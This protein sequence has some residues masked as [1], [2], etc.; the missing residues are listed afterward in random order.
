MSF[1]IIIRGPLGIGKSTI[2]KEL[3]RRL[4][5]EYISIDTILEELDLDHIDEGLGCIA[6]E[7]FLRVNQHILPKIRQSLE[8][9]PVVIDGNFYHR[10]QIQDLEENLKN[11]HYVFTLKAPLSVCIQRDSQRP[12]SY[13]KGAATAVHNLVSKFDSGTRINTEDK[14]AE[15]IVN[16]ILS[17]IK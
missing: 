10:E 5:A 2:S 12:K 15:E 4:K 6:P 9:G 17:Y 14:T 8:R 1:Y 13:G 7:N 11:T 3:A 16:E